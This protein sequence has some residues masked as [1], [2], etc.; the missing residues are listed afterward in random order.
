MDATS[1][2]APAPSR[3]A[4]LTP[5]DWVTIS[6]AGLGLLFA[7]LVA[8]TLAGVLPSRSWPLFFLLIPTLA[9]D[10]V[11]GAVARRT[12]TVTARGARWDMEVDAAVLLAASLAVLPYA[13]WAL[14]IGLARYLYGLGAWLRPRWRTPLPFR[15]SRR[16]IAAFQGIALAVALAPF[17]P[18]WLGQGVTAVALALLA[19]SFAR[20]VGYQEYR[21][22][23]PDTCVRPRPK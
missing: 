4:P 20:D 6:R 22:P 1:P 12:G 14:A 10:G 15:Q 19:Y 23:Q 11:D 8:L 21:A 7:V 5:A 18:I 3:W 17:L 9:L 16:V 13:P 2:P